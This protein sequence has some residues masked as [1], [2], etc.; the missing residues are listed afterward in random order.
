MQKTSISLADKEEIVFLPGILKRYK[1]AD[2]VTAYKARFVFYLCMLCILSIFCIMIYSIYLQLNNPSSMGLNYNV[3]AVE[4]TVLLFFI[5]ALLILVKGHFSVA[6]NLIILVSLAAVWLVM[7]NSQTSLI[8]NLDSIVF[9]FVILAMTPV[10]V[11]HRSWLLVFY[12]LV[13]IPVLWIYMYTQNNFLQLKSTQFFDYLA[14]NTI[15]LAAISLILWNIFIINRNALNRLEKDIDRRKLAER[16]LEKSKEEM[17]SLLR[18]QN[19][20]L[21]TAAIWIDTLDVNGNVTSWNRAAESISGYSRAEVMGHGKIWEWLYPDGNYRKMIFDKATDIIRNGD[22]VENFETSII[23]KDG[24]VRIISWSS[25]KLVDV[26]GEPAGSLALGSDIT[27]RKREQEEKEKLEE[28]ILQMQKMDSI[29]RLAGGIAHDFNN[30]LTAI[31]GSA[32]LA[33]LKLQPDDQILKNFITIKKAAE[34][35]ANL[36]KQLLSFSRKQVIEPRVISLNDVVEHMKGML[37]RMIGENIRFKTIP[38]A[39]LCMIN[40]D[41]GQLEQILINLVVNARDAMPGGGD[42]TLETL[43]V[44][45]DEDYC[46]SHARIE[47]GSYAMLAVSDTGRGMGREIREHIF[48][49]FFTTKA[50]GMGTGLGLATVYGAVRQSGGSIEFYSEEGHGTTFKI[51]FPCIAGDRESVYKV[52]QQEESPAG[53]ETILVV[54]DN[55]HVLD[56]VS[57]SLSRLGYTVLTAVNGEEAL[58]TAGDYTGEIHMVMTDVILTGMNGRELAVKIRELR[59]GLKVLYNSGYSGDLISRSGIIEENIN[60]IGK[61]FS[62]V[63][64]ARKVRGVLDG[65]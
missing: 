15:G 32:E 63:M 28:Q 33:M 52:Q 55:P 20:M 40:A 4:A 46:S 8:S 27:D 37:E 56:F 58:N 26:K 7:L 12:S 29:G 43:N 11:R 9:I 34:S 24:D 31:L 17:S 42:L 51:Y 54:E 10:M 57:T 36:T 44:Q 48:E 1:D 45:I 64:L 60:F 61:P 53:S 25:N 41:P 2:L 65:E 14:D 39:E 21:D 35:A 22:H 47:P 49:P 3:T 19:E 30:L 5:F 18:F 59:P 6:S 50:S 16:E 62:A 38:C 13:N 23:R